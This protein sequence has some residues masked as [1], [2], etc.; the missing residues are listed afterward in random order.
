MGGVLGMGKEGGGVGEGG[1]L[2]LGVSCVLGVGN[3][4]GGVGVRG[5]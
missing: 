4:C 3:E 2:D 5:V 1:I